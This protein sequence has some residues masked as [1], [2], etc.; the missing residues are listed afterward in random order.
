MPRRCATAFAW[1]GFVCAFTP[2]VTGHGRHLFTPELVG[3][4][5]TFLNIGTMGGV[6]MQ[7]FF[8]GFVVAGMTG[9][10]SVRPVAAYSGVFLCVAGALLVALVFYLRAPDAEMDSA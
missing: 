2:L 10:A 9:E 6:F 5:I 4:G 3:R 1:F 7:Q 8:T